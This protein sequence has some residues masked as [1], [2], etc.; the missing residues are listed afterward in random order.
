LT[1][2]LRHQIDADLAQL[3]GNIDTPD[4]KLPSYLAALAARDTAAYNLDH[5]TIRAAADGRV[6]TVTVSGAG[7]S[8][9]SVCARRLPST[10]RR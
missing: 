4:E 5:A 2:G 8:T 10:S 7:S 9:L 3:G 6:G 1:S